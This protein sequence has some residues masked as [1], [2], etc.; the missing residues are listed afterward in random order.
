MAEQKVTRWIRARA[1]RRQVV[2]HEE[3]AGRE[4]VDRRLRLLCTGGVE[5]QEV[6]RPAAGQM[7]TPVPEEELDVVQAAQ[8]LGRNL[9][10]QRIGLDGDERDRRRGDR[11]CAF[12]E[13]RAR[14]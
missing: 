6:E 3:A 10:T 8:S 13:R 4:Q 1:A 7:L 2:L 5:E 12:A 9:R 14:L 11:G